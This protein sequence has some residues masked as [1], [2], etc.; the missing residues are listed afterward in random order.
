M[1]DFYHALAAGQLLSPD[2]LTEAVTVQCSGTDRVFGG[3]N[4]WGLGFGVD[5]DGYGMGGLGGSSAFTSTEGGYSI[6]FVTGSMGAHD[7]GTALEN[8]V[9]DCLGLTPL[10]PETS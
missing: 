1:A 9:R 6:A 4:A 10:A 7:R 2:L 5:A 3:D 8:S